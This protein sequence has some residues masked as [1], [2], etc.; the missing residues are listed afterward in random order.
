MK[1][2]EI[3]KRCV[4]I[5]YFGLD[6]TEEGPL[7]FGIGHV[8]GQFFQVTLS[9][10]RVSPSGEFIRC[11]DFPGDELMGWQRTEMLIAAEILGFWDGDTP[12]TMTL[13]KG[14]TVPE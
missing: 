13:G 6:R 12:P 3:T 8:P 2:D 9:P 7:P 4:A 14:V 1:A 10:D 11:G 5:V